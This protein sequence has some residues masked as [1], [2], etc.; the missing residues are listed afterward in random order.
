MIDEPDDTSSNPQADTHLPASGEFDANNVPS[1]S[2]A[3]TSSNEDDNNSA[4]PNNVNQISAQN[5]G[6]TQDAPNPA[7]P[8]DPTKIGNPG[9]DGV[10]SADNE[11][12]VN[13]S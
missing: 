11:A 4:D 3:L 2:S 9:D 13:P 5:T 12:I 10:A 7:G 1:N 6:Q 8:A